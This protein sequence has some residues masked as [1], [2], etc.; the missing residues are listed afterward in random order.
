MHK[1]TKQNLEKIIL[2]GYGFFVCQTEKKRFENTLEQM[3][4]IINKKS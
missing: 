2:L 3:I 1:S 4:L